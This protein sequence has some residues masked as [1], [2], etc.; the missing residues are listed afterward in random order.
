MLAIKDV[1]AE[2]AIVDRDHVMFS[3]KTLLVDA[4]AEL[5]ASSIDI[6][7]PRS[8][9]IITRTLALLCE[10]YLVAAAGELASEDDVPPPLEVEDASEV[11]PIGERG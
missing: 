5:P 3:S 8:G 11:A 9:G 7:L 4:V 1:V 10:C 2:P 6:M